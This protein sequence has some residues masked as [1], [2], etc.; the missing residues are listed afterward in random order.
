MVAE[1]DSAAACSEYR[2]VWLTPLLYP[3]SYKSSK[4]HLDYRGRIGS[5][6]NCLRYGYIQYIHVQEVKITM[7]DD[8]S[9]MSGRYDDLSTKP[10]GMSQ[11]APFNHTTSS[12]PI[13]CSSP[14]RKT[15]SK[16]HRE[17]VTSPCTTPEQTGILTS[18]STR[19]SSK[20]PAKSKASASAPSQPTRLRA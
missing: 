1:V 14:Q 19:S 18:S 2:R 7:S 16:C 15:P 3:T 11:T 6:K 4:S 12:Y 8:G 5:I 17:C 9:V 20:S 10:H 13:I